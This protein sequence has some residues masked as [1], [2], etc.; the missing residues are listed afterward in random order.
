MKVTLEINM[1]NAA[2]EDNPFELRSLLLIAATKVENQMMRDENVI[3]IAPEA[4][5][6]ILDSNGNTVGFVKLEKD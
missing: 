1:D 4:D 5:D 6:K 3:C 2:F